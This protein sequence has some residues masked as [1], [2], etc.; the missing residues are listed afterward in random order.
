MFQLFDSHIKPLLD[1][2]KPKTILEIGVL[3]GDSTLKILEWCAVNGSHLTSLDPVGWEGN[4]PEEVKK[5]MDNYQ[6]KRGQSEFDNY[7]VPPHALEEVFKRG[8]DTNWTCIKTRSLDYLDSDNFN[9]FDAYI[10]DGDNNYYTVYREL[11]LIH[12]KYKPT[13]VVL[14]NDI[15]GSWARRDLYYDLSFIPP[16][17]VNGRK[18]G[19]LTAINAFL[20]FHS[21][22]ML[23]WRKKCLYKFKIIT[24]KHNG[25]GVLTRSY[26]N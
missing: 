26:D 24:K 5:P 8:L 21:E 11:E 10:I 16:E 4:L 17:Y 14:Y 1:E 6:Y 13:D 3:R 22:K 18:Q 2:L 23:F 20:D 12:R 7:S 15:S 25:L 19:V 9:G